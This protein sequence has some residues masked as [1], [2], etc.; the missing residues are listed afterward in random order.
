MERVLHCSLW[1]KLILK[2]NQLNLPEEVRGL[3]Y[4]SQVVNLEKEEQRQEGQR[5]EEHRREGEEHRREHLR[6]QRREE[7]GQ[8][9]QRREEQG[10]GQQKEE[11]MQTVERDK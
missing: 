2:R 8:E 1:E 5:R 6:E 4:F 11:Q 10:Q 3:H 9:G 7:Q